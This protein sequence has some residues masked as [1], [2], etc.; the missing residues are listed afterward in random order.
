VHASHAAICALTRCTQQVADC[1]RSSSRIARIAGFA[2]HRFAYTA[3]GTCLCVEA[4]AGVTPSSRSVCTHRGGGCTSMPC[5]W[6]TCSL[7]RSSSG[8]AA[9]TD[10]TSC[11]PGGLPRERH[12]RSGGP[13]HSCRIQGAASTGSAAGHAVLCWSSGGCA[14]QSG[15]RALHVSCA[16]SRRLGELQRAPP[17]AWAPCLRLLASQRATNPAAERG[18]AL[19]ADSCMV[20]MPAPTTLKPEEAGYRGCGG[21][22]AVHAR[23]SGWE[24]SMVSPRQL[25]A[26]GLR[27]AGAHAGE[28]AQGGT[29]R[30]GGAFTAQVGRVEQLENAAEAKA[31]RGPK[32]RPHPSLAVPPGLAVAPTPTACAAARAHSIASAA[33]P[34]LAAC[35][36]ARCRRGGHCVGFGLCAPAALPLL[37]YLLHGDVASRVHSRLRHHELQAAD[38]ASSPACAAPQRGWAA[39]L[40]HLCILGA[41]V[42]KPGRACRLC[43]VG[44]VCGRW[45]SLRGR[46]DPPSAECSGRLLLCCAGVHPEGAHPDPHSRHVSYRHVS[47]HHPPHGV[48]PVLQPSAML[49]PCT[50]LQL[51]SAELQPSALQQ[52][53]HGPDTSSH[54]C[55]CLM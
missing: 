25:L 38:N 1:G 52:C 51:Q 34:Q 11:S 3:R 19:H 49:W 43:A 31:L 27:R 54:S 39:S 18:S 28:L 32:V 12:Q 17:A 55:R 37:G 46:L 36:S 41:C 15:Q 53:G 14:V 5:W 29:H 9:L 22:L 13:P 48:P 45:A 47:G 6:R 26:G 33:E 44:V 4:A 21:A 10:S 8:S 20:R 30:T 40:R 42:Q 16:I 24:C 7:L 2:K 50:H 23:G 35:G